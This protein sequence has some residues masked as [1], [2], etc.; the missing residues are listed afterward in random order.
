MVDQLGSQP[1]PNAAPHRG[2]MVAKS[3]SGGTGPVDRRSLVEEAHSKEDSE[4]RAFFASIAASGDPQ[5]REAA[6]RAMNAKME[7]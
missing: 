3:A 1:D 2:V 6:R 4:R 5:M 7:N